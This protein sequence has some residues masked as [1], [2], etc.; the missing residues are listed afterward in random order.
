MLVRLTLLGVAGAA[1]TLARYGVQIGV[2]QR[3]GHPAVGTFIVN[4]LGCLALGIAWG[5]LDRRDL[6]AGDLR[7]VLLTGLLGAFTTFSALM[8]DTARLARDTSVALAVLNIGGQ[9]VVG[10]L[11]LAAGVALGRLV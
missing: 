2:V 7:L 1:G 9:V 11:L 3:S 10:L 6:L 5:M 4:V 8:F